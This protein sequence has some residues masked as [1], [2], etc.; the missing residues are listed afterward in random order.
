MGIFGIQQMWA[1]TQFET[2]FLLGRQ[3]TTISNNNIRRI[4]DKLK[5]LF[6]KSEGIAQS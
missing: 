3:I 6:N 1:L 4:K 5:E 2:E